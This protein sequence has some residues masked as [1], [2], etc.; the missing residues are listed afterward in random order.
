[1]DIAK[2]KAAKAAGTIEIR[3]YGKNSIGFIQRQFD[4]VS[5]E[6]TAPASGAFLR[7]DLVKTRETLEKDLASVNELLD[8]VDALG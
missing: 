5:G 8:D 7:D 1:M 3:K 4:P 6:E 2:Y